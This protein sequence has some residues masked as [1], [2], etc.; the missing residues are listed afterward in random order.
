MT[1]ITAL[2]SRMSKN[3]WVRITEVARTYHF[4]NGHNLLVQY[5]YAVWISDSG[6]H[7][8][9]RDVMGVVRTIVPA[10]WIGL[11][12]EVPIAKDWVHPPPIPAITQT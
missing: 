11:T 7:Y 3:E 1:L 9:A 10:G 8:I 5:P 4:P 12:I 6:T 2:L